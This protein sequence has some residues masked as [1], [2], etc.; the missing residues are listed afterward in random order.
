MPSPPLRIMAPSGAP[1][2]KKI[3]IDTGSD[4]FLCHS[5]LYRYNWFSASLEVA[6]S[7]E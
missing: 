6:S 4:I 3:M 2:R 7:N 5:T 1:I